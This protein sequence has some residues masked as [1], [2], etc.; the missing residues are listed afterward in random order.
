MNHRFTNSQT[1][2]RKKNVSE[3]K[4]LQ[5]QIKPK[6][7]GTNSVENFKAENKQ[8]FRTGVRFFLNTVNF[9]TYSQQHCDIYACITHVM[10]YTHYTYLCV[11]FYKVL[12]ICII[13]RLHYLCNG[14]V[15]E[16]LRVSP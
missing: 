6:Y 4:L 14:R 8:A 5:R 15:N 7:A 13:L 9:A 16:L 11:H 12:S 10:Q 2:K 1:V 3:Q